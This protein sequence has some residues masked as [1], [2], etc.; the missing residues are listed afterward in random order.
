MH[1]VWSKQA[2]ALTMDTFIYRESIKSHME[3]HP[4]LR[5]V[6]GEDKGATEWGLNFINKGKTKVNG[7]N[8]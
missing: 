5:G 8:Y 6:I 2:Y 4:E 1:T 3:Q 7:A